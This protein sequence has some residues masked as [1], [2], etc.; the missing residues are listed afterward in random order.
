PPSG[1]PGGRDPYAP[2]VC[3]KEGTT[4]K[5]LLALAVVVGLL[6]A[7]GCG[8]ETKKTQ[9]SSKTTATKTTGEGGTTTPTT[10]PKE[11]PP[12][13]T[14]PETKTPAEKTTPPDKGTETKTETKTEAEKTTKKGGS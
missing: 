9:G 11:N 10:T 2:W 3:R 7:V 13:K 4:V 14:M 8:S 1:R 5:K 12:E 6:G